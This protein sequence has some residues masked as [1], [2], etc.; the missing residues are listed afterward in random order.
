MMVHLDNQT[1]EL[2][3]L[4]NLRFD[5]PQ[6]PRYT[7]MYGNSSTEVVVDSNLSLEDAN[8][9]VTSTYEESKS[10]GASYADKRINLD[11][12]YA[13]LTIT[14]PDGK[15]LNRVIYTKEEE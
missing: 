15:R 13:E 9:L 6:D 10:L 12:G 8:N 1:N 3:V 4:Q 7:L 2:V 14:Y 11:E 5:L